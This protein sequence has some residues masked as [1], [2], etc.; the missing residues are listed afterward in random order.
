MNEL[1]FLTFKRVFLGYT[2]TRPEKCV[3]E[4]FPCSYCNSC[5]TDNIVE[6]KEE[7]I[8]YSNAREGV[9]FKHHPL[10][11]QGTA[12]WVYKNT[13]LTGYTL[14]D[15]WRPVFSSKREKIFA[16]VRYDIKRFVAG[17][18]RKLRQ[19]MIRRVLLGSYLP[20]DII[21]FIGTF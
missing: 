16:K 4:L 11:E 6:A 20:V 15:M 5:W 7:D 17:F 19:N 12:Y 21:R 9:A 13:L 8:T 18:M 14:N 2:C 3:G 10:V 1:H